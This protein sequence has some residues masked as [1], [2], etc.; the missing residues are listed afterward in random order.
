MFSVPALVEMIDSR[1]ASPKTRLSQVHFAGSVGG[2]RP[3]QGPLDTD[4]RE[5]LI[6]LRGEGFDIVFKVLGVDLA[7]ERSSITMVTVTLDGTIVSS[8]P[9]LE[10][11]QY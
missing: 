10:D 2:S 4:F 5:K 6:R 7:D 1:R 11:V 3:Y 8:E 9:A